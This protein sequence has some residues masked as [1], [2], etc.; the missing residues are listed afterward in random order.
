MKPTDPTLGNDGSSRDGKATWDTATWDE[1]AYDVR[2]VASDQ[3]GNAPAEALTAQA[4]LVETVRV[5]RTPPAIEGKRSGANIEAVVTDALSPILRLEVVVDG[6]VE[7]S[8]RAAD[9]VCDGLRETFRF[10]AALVTGSGT[11]T[12]RATDAA[13]NAVESPV[14]SR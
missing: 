8:P 11:W 7:F 12:L 10:P 1:G 2:A 14:P 5:D 9:G 4:D 13:G 6:R 3:P